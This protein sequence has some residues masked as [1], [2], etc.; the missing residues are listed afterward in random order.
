MRYLSS[1]VSLIGNPKSTD[2]ANAS[3]IDFF[4]RTLSVIALNF[5]LGWTN[6]NLFPAF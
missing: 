2:C 6:N 1:F 4:S 5:K 3:S